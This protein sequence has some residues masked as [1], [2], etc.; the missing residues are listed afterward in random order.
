[1][2]SVSCAFL[3][4]IIVCGFALAGD[5]YFGTVQVSAQAPGMIVVISSDTTWT[6]A[7]NP[8]TLTG[9]LLVSEGAT[10]TIEAGATVN[11]NSYDVVVNGTLRAIGSSAEKV[12]LNNGGTIELTQYSNGWDEETGSGSIFKHVFLDDLDIFSSVSLKIKNSNLDGEIS[13]AGSSMIQDNTLST[14]SITGGSA[15]VSNNAISSIIDCYGA[16]EISYNTIGS[17]F[18]GS[19]GSPIISYNT[20]RSIGDY[21][22]YYSGDS[23]IIK[24]NI[25][26]GRL[27][28]A[29]SSAIISNNTFSGYVYGEDLNAGYGANLGGYRPIIAFSGKSDQAGSSVISHNK[30]RGHTYEY[31]YPFIVPP[32]RTTLNG[33]VTT[34]GISITGAYADIYVINNT[35]TDCETGISGGTL[36]EGNSLINNRYGIAIDED[37]VIIRNNNITNGDTGISGY[38]GGTATIENNFI[39]NHSH[40]GIDITLQVTIKNNTISNTSTAIRLA[41]CLSATIDYNNIENY[42]ENSIYLQGTSSNIDA[43]Y[44]WWGTTDTQAINL[45]IHDSKYSFDLGTVSFVPFFTEPNPEASEVP[46]PELTPTLTTHI[47]ISVDISSTVVGSTVN[48]NGRLTDVNG[49]AL[50]DKLVTLSYSITGNDW[51]PIGSGTTNAA[52][53]YNIQWVNTASG[54]FTLKVK[55]IGNDDY[56]RASA[57]TTLSFLPHQSQNIFFVESNSTVSAL[58]FNNTNAEL[59]FTVSGSSGTSGYVKATISKDLLYTEG[60]WIVLVDEQPVIPTVNENANNTY[61]YFTYGHSTKTVE[62]IGTYAIPEFPSWTP[63]LIMLVSVMF[64]VVIYR[65]ILT[66]PNEWRNG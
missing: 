1:M 31:S 51:V 48:V 22:S 2:K 35:I 41:N 55:W 34:S 26:V 18:A 10:L 52:G 3:I 49:S 25:I 60:D 43:A 61:L 56:L 50:Q 11:L 29:A 16:P 20:I 12:Q 32:A 63:I 24:N 6:K 5:I 57:N 47:S 46:E 9:P 36:I 33:T 64:V 7:D 13:V 38:T 27:C 23:P 21:N 59:S 65:S 37:T 30:I 17:I 62:I 45:T 40:Y 42:S 53:E 15:V 28:L 4:A 58:T 66:K 39:S 19:G 54:T 44:N 14:L 8:H